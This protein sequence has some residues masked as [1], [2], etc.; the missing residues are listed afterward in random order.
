MKPMPIDIYDPAVWRKYG[1]SLAHESDY[2]N[3]YA[4]R[5]ARENGVTGK[6]DELQK[7]RALSEL[8]GYLAAVLQRTRKYHQALNARST[9]KPPVNYYVFAG[10]CEETLQALVILHDPKSG[11]YE[12][13]TRPQEVRGSD[14][15]RF[16]RDEVR[17][18]MFG[19]GDGRVTRRSLLAE[20]FA[21]E[22][23]ADSPYKTTLPLSHSFL[24]CLIH[25][26]I[27][28]SP[29]VHNSALTFLVNDAVR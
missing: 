9:I 27:Q 10:D 25:G 7:L 8:D 16:S 11:R 28:D 2:R 4:Q 26:Y 23:P 24:I 13:L 17:R 14:K 12:T 6:S 15:R 19:P 20:T 1:W 3:R 18:L 22:R 21:A 29:N 5:E